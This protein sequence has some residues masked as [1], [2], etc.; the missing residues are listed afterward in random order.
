MAET[1]QI[2]FEAVDEVSST[3][4]SIKED[5]DSLSTTQIGI[6]LSTIAEGLT[7]IKESLSSIASDIKAENVLRQELV[8]KQVETLE[9]ISESFSS[10]EPLQ[11]TLNASG[12][13]PAL[14]LVWE[15]IL[16]ALQGQVVLEGGDMLAS[17]LSTT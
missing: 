10:D 8:D 6:D 16:T 7:S 1:I 14:E 12:L 4:Q 9:A 5:L 11:I 15:E 2:K 3:I 13:S 17:V